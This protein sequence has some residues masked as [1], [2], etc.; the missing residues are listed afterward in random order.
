MASLLRDRVAVHVTHRHVGRQRMWRRHRAVL[1][2]WEH[3]HRLQRRVHRWCL[4]SVRQRRRRLLH[5]QLLQ[6]PQPRSAAAASA[7]SAVPAQSPAVPLAARAA[8]ISCASLVSALRAAAPEK[9]AAATHVA[10]PTSCAALAPACRAVPAQSPAA[11]LATRAASISCAPLVSARRAGASEKTAAAATRAATSTSCATPPR[12]NANAADSA[13]PRVPHRPR[14]R[15]RSRR[16]HQ[17]MVAWGNS[18]PGSL[19]AS[20][21]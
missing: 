16:S 2:T 5:R 12:A 17:S 11:L 7:S 21:C 3:V 1:P 8:S 10:V 19:S 14:S 13:S 15:N 4:H 18:C 9:Y 20:C 6:Q